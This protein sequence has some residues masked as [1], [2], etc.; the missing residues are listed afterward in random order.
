MSRLYKHSKKP[1]NTKR[2][3]G[4]YHS[5]GDGSHASLTLKQAAA[6]A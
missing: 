5:Q 1:S 2:G 4:R 6:N 3:P